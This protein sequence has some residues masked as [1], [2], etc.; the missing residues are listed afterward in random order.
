MLAFSHVHKLTIK[1]KGQSR[2]FL[3][4][5]IP[6]VEGEGGVHEHIGTISKNSMFRRTDDQK[7]EYALCIPRSLTSANE[8]ALK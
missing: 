3:K 2:F 7:T 6:F 5:Y 4:I 8:N 1:K